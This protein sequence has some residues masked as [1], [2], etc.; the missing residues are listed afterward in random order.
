M[1]MFFHED[2]GVEE[3]ELVCYIQII[4]FEIYDHF[5]Y[6]S[7]GMLCKGWRSHKY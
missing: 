7:K 1:K 3:T 5:Q 2:C 4:S 6:E